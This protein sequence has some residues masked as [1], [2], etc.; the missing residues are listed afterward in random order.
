MTDTGTG[1]VAR[2]VARCVLTLRKKK[3]ERKKQSSWAFSLSLFWLAASCFINLGWEA[4]EAASC[5]PRPQPV[6]G[7]QRQHLSGQLL[8]PSAAGAGAGIYGH[9]ATP[10]AFMVASW[11][12]V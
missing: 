1:L 9:R 4:G 6:G 2:N 5:S 3:K 8:G 12:L 11:Q 10:G 7:G